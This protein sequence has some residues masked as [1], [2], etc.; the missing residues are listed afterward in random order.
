MMSLEHK[1][2]SIEETL[3]NFDEVLQEK[4]LLIQKVI[5]IQS[6]LNA[7]YEDYHSNNVFS[8]K[9]A[10]NKKKRQVELLNIKVNYLNDEISFLKSCIDYIGLKR[11]IENI[12][13]VVN[14]PDSM[15]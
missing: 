11:E 2:K 4:K 5:Q 6:E 15:D 7:S 9:Y 12:K 1:I 14:E 3:I 10:I 8:D 13:Q